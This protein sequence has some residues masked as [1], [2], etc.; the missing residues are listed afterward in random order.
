M[1]QKCKGL[2]GY[3]LTESF[4]LSVNRLLSRSALNEGCL[5]RGSLKSRV[6]GVTELYGKMQNPPEDLSNCYAVL[7]EMY[8][9]FMDL[10]GCATDPSGSLTTF[11][12]TFSEADD[13]FI[14]CYEK[15]GAMIPSEPVDSTAE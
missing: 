6:D 4:E 3:S 8:D 1:E 7:G 12:S 10:T 9:A 2:L 14:D 15:L 11:S 13:D 5:F